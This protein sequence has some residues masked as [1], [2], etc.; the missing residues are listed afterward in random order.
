MFGGSL[1]AKEVGVNRIVSVAFD[2]ENLDTTVVPIE[3][4]PQFRVDGI[5]A[6]LS[7]YEDEI[8]ENKLANS[9]TVEI[10]KEVLNQY[11]QFE[12]NLTCYYDRKDWVYFDRFR[13]HDLKDIEI[14][15]DDGSNNR[16]FVPWEDKEG[17]PYVN[18]LCS[19]Y[20]LDDGNLFLEVL[21]NG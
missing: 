13:H 21:K 14:I 7:L 19:T 18:E 10:S 3:F 20:V 9:I 16:I 11:R 6:S 12:G 15:Y 2:F 8:E 5:T 1:N 17:N 4:I